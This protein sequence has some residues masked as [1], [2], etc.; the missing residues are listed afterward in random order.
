MNIPIIEAEVL[1]VEMDYKTTALKQKLDCKFDE[2][3]K[4]RKPILWPILPM[5][6]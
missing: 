2:G 1:E 5:S 6:F 4:E 3:V